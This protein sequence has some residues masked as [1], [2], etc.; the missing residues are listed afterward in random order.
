MSP[1]ICA[2]LLAAAIIPTTPA[3]AQDVIAFRRVIAKPTMN[4]DPKKLA[5]VEGADLR[6]I[7]WEVSG[8][9]TPEGLKACGKV[10]Q[11]RLRGCV[12]NGNQ[13]DDAACPQ[14]A[15]ETIRSGEDY[16]G[17]GYQWRTTPSGP[18]RDACSSSTTRSVAAGCVRSDGVAMPDSRCTTPRPTEE[19]GAN[20]AGCTHSWS[21][22]D[23]KPWD[24][25][26]S[27]RANR[28]RDVQCLRSNGDAVSPSMCGGSAPETSQTG[29]NLSGCT[30]AWRTG[31]WSAP[32]STCST[33]AV[34]TRVNT[35]MR[36][37]QTT[38]DASSCTDAQPPVR[39]EVEVLTGC[40]FSWSSGE[41]SDWSSTCSK[42]AQRT[43]P[44]QCLRSDG[45]ATDDKSCTALRPPS[46]ES[47]DVS[48]SCG[49]R[50][51][52]GEW[53]RPA[54]CNTKAQ[55]ERT[56][57]CRR[58]DGAEAGDA[59]CEGPVPA[60]TETYSDLSACTYS[61]KPGA[62]SAPDS[63]CS[64]AATRTRT[65]SCVRSDGEAA[66][67]MCGDKST[68][69]LTD[70]MPI[71]TGCATSWA[72]G[73]WSSYNSTCSATSTRTRPV[74]CN[75]NR[76][77]ETVPV[78]ARTCDASTRPAS[79][80]S[81]GIYTSCAN[82]WVSGTW[83]WNGVA[84]AVSSTCDTQAQQTQ[85]PTCRA[86]LSD[87]TKVTVPDSNCDPAKKPA[88]TRTTSSVSSCSYRW[89]VG[90]WTAWGSTCSA[91]S[92]RTRAVACVQSD[93]LS[94]VVADS[95]CVN[96]G[97]GSTPLRS[98]SRSN[99]TDCTG[100]LSDPGFEMGGD[101]WT[102]NGSG[103]STR[104]KTGAKG[105]QVYNGKPLS[106]SFQTIAGKRYSLS[107]WVYGFGGMGATIRV[108]GNLV[109]SDPVGG[110]NYAWFQGGGSFTGNGG[111]MKLEVVQNSWWGSGTSVV[112]DDVV[113]SP[114]P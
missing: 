96:K 43:R 75:Q 63:T 86:T 21:I 56:V 76:P 24:S 25:A 20:Y 7:H 80:D 73:E 3:L 8:W 100:L 84:G 90:E 14:P 94:T 19:T 2:L 60:R 105:M 6:R 12:L 109:V 52:I 89:S 22:G 97:L 55:A 71:Y 78:D 113:L 47:G 102:L 13:V 53:S 58:S 42:T 36:A 4:R 104:A 99:V 54:A 59:S 93:P 57:V 67:G 101:G 31:A 87:G 40:S 51:E 44:V 111:A 77:S 82:V 74:T 110:S 61:W 10:E 9:F 48:T 50:W 107:F 26:C 106:Q 103:I 28:K 98:E 11:V 16:S 83:G 95:T 85:T 64:D 32:D 29:E 69:P 1:K 46:T 18:W 62:W 70:V 45:T 5:P 49:Y 81:V 112:V 33:K 27:T 92:T 72:T 35:C 37:D 108:D 38:A 23:W 39:Q 114:E 79:S 17:C 66:D 30:F 34:Q 41:W 88:T 15:P 91:S 68:P 65:A